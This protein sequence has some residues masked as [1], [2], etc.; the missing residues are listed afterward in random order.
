M[1]ERSH[2]CL[3]RSHTVWANRSQGEICPYTG[4]VPFL[5]RNPKLGGTFF[6]LLALC[7]RGKEEQNVA[8]QIIDGIIRHFLSQL[9]NQPADR[10][11]C[12]TNCS[13]ECRHYI[14]ASSGLNPRRSVCS[15]CPDGA[16]ISGWAGSLGSAGPARHRFSPFAGLA[17]VW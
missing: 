7:L 13:E 1:E 6:K 9:L 3:D 10:L 4:V 8:F 11:P 2:T 15:S 17:T 12:C 5:E 16:P 14:A